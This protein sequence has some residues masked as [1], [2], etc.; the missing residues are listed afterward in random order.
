MTNSMV[1]ATTTPAFLGAVASIYA[2]N[3][4]TDFASRAK[5]IARE[6]DRT[7]PDLV[8]LQ[9]HRDGTAG[10]HQTSG[11]HRLISIG[12]GSNTNDGRVLSDA[13]A[14]LNFLAPARRRGGN[15]GRSWRRRAG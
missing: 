11:P 8:G 4:A 9:E 15:T 6:I 7:E 13:R 5:A 2:A 3:Q 14:N 10:R 12:S 1:Q